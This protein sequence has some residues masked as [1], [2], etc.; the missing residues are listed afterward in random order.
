MALTVMADAPSPGNT[1]SV[2]WLAPNCSGAV[3]PFSL[4]VAEPMVS[5]FHFSAGQKAVLWRIRS[6][7]EQSLPSCDQPKIVSHK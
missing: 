6:Y 5:L 1:A 3:N 7:I 2:Y 4:S